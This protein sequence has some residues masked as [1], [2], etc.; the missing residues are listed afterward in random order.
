VRIRNKKNG[1]QLKINI[2]DLI[3]KR[4]RWYGHIFRMKTESQ[5]GF[6]HE[7]KRKRPYRRIKIKMGTTN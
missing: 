5:E 3:N 4:R 1:D 2:L 7:N 6:K